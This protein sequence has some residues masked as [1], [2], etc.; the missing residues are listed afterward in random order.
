VACGVRQYE[1]L[2]RYAKDMIRESW[3]HPFNEGVTEYFTQLIAD[4]DGNPPSKGGP[5]RIHYPAKLGVRA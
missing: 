3:G 4:R 1:C 2:H 5:S